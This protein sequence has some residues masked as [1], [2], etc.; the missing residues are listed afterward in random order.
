M[1]FKIFVEATTYENIIMLTP[2]KHF[3]NPFSKDP[4]CLLKSHRSK[5]KSL[6][7]IRHNTIHKDVAIKFY[8]LKFCLNFN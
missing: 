1:N 2:L 6:N 4:F 3:N 5:W 8:K 7:K